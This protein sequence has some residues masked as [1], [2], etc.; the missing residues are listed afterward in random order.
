MG[1]VFVHRPSLQRRTS[2][3]RTLCQL[4]ISY[5][6]VSKA[7]CRGI[8]AGL[9]ARL[10]QF[11]VGP[12]NIC[13]RTTQHGPYAIAVRPAKI[14]LLVAALAGCATLPPGAD[15]PRTVS[16]ALAHPEETHLGEQFARAAQQ[17]DGASGFRIATVGVDG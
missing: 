14:L 10:T 6:Y 15:F 16:V 1:Y 8:L 13:K 17:H 4:C 2:A 3:P 7:S 5:G 12:A 9:T 11:P